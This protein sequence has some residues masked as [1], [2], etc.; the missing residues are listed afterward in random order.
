VNAYIS[1]L[2][3]LTDIK[4]VSGHN[5]Y[6]SKECPGFRVKTADWI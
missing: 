1:E 2:S 5:D 4:K 3:K 6:A